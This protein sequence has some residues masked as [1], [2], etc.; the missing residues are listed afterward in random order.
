MLAMNMALGSVSGMVLQVQAADVTNFRFLKYNKDNSNLTEVNT[1]AVAGTKLSILGKPPEGYQVNGFNVTKSPNEN[2]TAQKLLD[3]PSGDQSASNG[4]RRWELNVDYRA[5]DVADS[6]RSPEYVMEAI[7]NATDKIE[8]TGTLAGE[9][10]YIGEKTPFFTLN[11]IITTVDPESGFGI[12]SSGSFSFEAEYTAFADLSETEPKKCTY[13]ITQ[14]TWSVDKYKAV[15]GW[16]S[17]NF[18][19]GSTGIT[20]GTGT[21]TQNLEISL[22]RAGS[23]TDV[24]LSSKKFTVKIPPSFLN[25]FKI[26][27]ERA[28][29]KKLEGDPDFKPVD[30]TVKIN[31]IV[32]FDCPTGNSMIL[33]VLSPTEAV[34]RIADLLRD[35]A[36]FATDEV[37]QKI[38]TLKNG[39]S[40]SDP[41]IGV[42]QDFTVLK[43]I[44]QFCSTDYEIV[45]E[46]VPTGTENQR[47]ANKDVIQFEGN[48]AQVLRQYENASGY[49]VARIYYTPSVNKDNKTNASA[50]SFENTAPTAITDFIDKLTDNEKN[51]EIDPKTSDGFRA[52]ICEGDSE[53]E[54]GVSKFQVVRATA[55]IP[56]TVVGTGDKPSIDLTQSVKGEIDVKEEDGSITDRKDELTN[57]S[58]KTT[59][60]LAVLKFKQDGTWNMDVYDAT[61]SSEYYKKSPEYPY[62]YDGVIQFGTLGSRAE[63]VVIEQIQKNAALEGN[64]KF[65]TGEIPE[66]TYGTPIK[67]PGTDKAANTQMKFTLQAAAPGTVWLRF[68]FFSDKGEIQES[69]Q[70]EF[71]IKVN[72]I[73]TSPS[74]NPAITLTTKAG[75]MNGIE[76]TKTEESLKENFKNGLIDF[77]FDPNETN[78]GSPQDPIHIPY[79][80]NQL[81]FHPL[82]EVETNQNPITL[83]AKRGSGIGSY[84]L[85]ENGDWTD[86]T[87][88][89]GLITNLIDKKNNIDTSKQPFNRFFLPNPIKEEEY[90]EDGKT[91]PIPKD[92]RVIEINIHTV[93]QDGTPRDYFIYIVRDEPSDDSALESLEVWSDNDK[94]RHTTYPL[95]PEFDPERSSEI[96]RDKDVV[97]SY[98]DVYTVHVPYRQETVWVHAMTRNHWASKI[99]ILPLKENGDPEEE[100]VKFFTRLRLNLTYQPEEGKL[101]NLMDKDNIDKPK[102]VLVRAIPENT[103]E[104]IPRKEYVLEI[105]RDPPDKN[106]NIKEPELGYWMKDEPNYRPSTEKKIAMTFFEN[107]LYDDIETEMVPYSI[108]SLRAYITPDSY[109]AQGVYAWLSRTPDS[110]RPADNTE[111]L[112]YL[113]HNDEEGEPR[114][115]EFRFDQTH[116]YFVENGASS[117]MYLNVQVIPEDPDIKNPSIYHIPIDRQEPNRDTTADITL[118]NTL[119]NAQVTADEGFDYS[120][121]KGVKDVYDVEIEYTPG[122]M[123]LLVQVIPTAETTTVAIGVDGKA[124]TPP[125]SDGMLVKLKE[126][127]TTVITIVLTAEDGSSRTITINVKYLPPSKNCYLKDLK[128]GTLL[129]R[130]IPTPFDKKKLNYK[131]EIPKGMTTIPITAWLLDDGS[132]DDSSKATITINDKKV[133]NGEPYNFTPSEKTGKIKVVVTAQDGKTKR[134]YTISY[135]NWN[136]LK[137]NDEDMLKDLWVDY[138]D[139]QPKFDSSITEYEVYLKPEAMDIKVYPKLRDSS[140]KI[141]V[142]AESKVLTEFEDY[143]STSLMDDEMDIHVYVWSEQAIVNNMSSNATGG[144]AAGGGGSATVLPDKEE[145]PP[146]T[147]AREYVLHLYRN[148]EEKIGNFKPLPAE[149]VDFVSSDPIVIDITQ[150]PIISA[151]VFKTLK[152]D[153]PDKSIIFKGNDYTLQIFGADIDGVI[154]NVES[155]DLR[156]SFRTPDEKKIR[157]AMDAAGNNS[158]I[159]PVY[160]YFNQHGALPAEMLLT[161]DLGRHYSNETLFWNYYN[162]ER[163]RIDYYGYVH[164]N[165]KGTFSVPIS[166]FSTYL[167]T[168][169]KIRGAENKSD[170]YGNPIPFTEETENLNSANSANKDIPNTAAPISFTVPSL[171]QTSA[172]QQ[173]VPYTSS[174]AGSVAA[175]TTAP[176]IDMALPERKKL[177]P[178]RKKSTDMPTGILK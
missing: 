122:D 132:K 88:G 62:K 84:S 59:A 113:V 92:N 143:Y 166:H 55:V 174:S 77:G 27:A 104:N 82:Y 156:F 18:P 170:E 10:V 64:I 36:E 140:C 157:D 101:I 44:K 5:G 94:K 124:P 159:E 108:G 155:F 86:E 41:G 46:W 176:A 50:D 116:P 130:P 60:E 16:F 76:G 70:L 96:K 52:A 98:E 168:D 75:Y 148:D 172:A 40:I 24:V 153:Y 38:I 178:V 39:D 33:T 4:N 11:K 30:F 103:D 7:L 102:R 109:L 72:I 137:P 93:A 123:Q 167:S 165:A 54:N 23:T 162:Q 95:D 3:V 35:R 85:N 49:I 152:E 42:S 120:D 118:T 177:S 131:I 142:T 25:R 134:T 144:G 121:Y 128:A 99:E 127:A 119:T 106:F 97:T 126:N 89:K 117:R 31:I 58:D 29:N 135:K 171:N 69:P 100:N 47:V 136:M 71:T 164:T 67:N 68:H 161:V 78:Y 26:E 73:D 112:Q 145:N 90:V 141:E 125:R 20:M 147:T 17:S 129:F 13:D 91:F 28:A 133:G 51:T 105:F 74:P 2:V 34:G 32:R 80:V 14:N 146:R 87:D 57:L 48:T 150:Y 56:I 173:P 139:M 63:R 111:G 22:D 151:D 45:W 163:D 154:P 37:G 65:S 160:Y 79:A 43:K 19:T 8:G 110:E 138:A 9:G 21:D 15:S 12:T 61:A 53:L 107:D 6:G 114:R 66:Y 149:D 175:R 83:T 158:H 81:T 1:T 115:L 169:E